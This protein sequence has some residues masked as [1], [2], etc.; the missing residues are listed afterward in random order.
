MAVFFLL[1]KIVLVTTS[2]ILFQS[3]GDLDTTR[4]VLSLVSNATFT[5]AGYDLSCKRKYLAPTLYYDVYSLYLIK[6]Q[7][8]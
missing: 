6:V 8:D 3:I 2:W 7:T 1:R 4:R 5:W